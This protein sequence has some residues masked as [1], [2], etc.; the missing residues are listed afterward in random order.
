MNPLLHLQHPFHFPAILPEHVEP[1]IDELIARSN[2]AL[3]ALRQPSAP[4]TFANTLLTLE[5]ATEALDTAITVVRHLESV[6]TTPE[7]RA[8][9]NAVQPKVSE[10]YSRIPLDE[11]IW[12][13]LKDFAATPEAQTLDRLPLRLLT[14]TMDGFRR[15]GADLDPAGKQR[16]AEIE[17]ELSQITTKFMENLLDSTN[18]FEHLITDESLLA[19]LPESAIAAARADAQSKE[20]PGWRFTL[21]Q[22]SYVAILTYLDHRPT[23]ELFYRAHITRASSPPRDNEPLIARILELRR[24]KGRLLGFADFSDLVL[25]DRMAKSGAAAQAFLEDL[26]VKTQ[27]FFERENRELADFAAFDLQPWDVGYYAEK[28]RRER[29]DFDEEE[30]RPYVAA[31]LVVN[32]L[33]DA[34]SRLYGITIEKRD[35]VPGWHPEVEYFEILDEDGTRL[36]GFYTDWFPRETKRGGAWMDCLQTGGPRPDGFH[37]HSGLMCGNLTP[38]LS[39][40][41]AL[42][43]HREV[44]TIWHE[45]GHL[46]HQL[47]SR[48][49]YRSFAGTSVPWDFVELPSQIMENWCWEREALDLFARHYETGEPI[50]Q[51][52]FEKMLR[53]RTF[54]SA[55]AQMRQLS[56]GLVDLKL[57]REFRGSN[58]V[59]FAREIMSPMSAAPLPPE[60]AMLNGF[61]HL[62]S[63]S[64]AYGSG[65]YSYKWAEVLDADAFSR[66]QQQGIFSGDVG[67]AFRDSIL[68]RGGTDDPDQL[69]RDFMGRD[70]DANALMV[71]SGLV[72]A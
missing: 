40:K 56:F 64:V 69:F 18:E 67:R 51:P 35:G 16:L 12:Q 15:A 44:E 38:P 71:R 54:R 43:T 41:P 63:S 48:V 28:L 14:K 19:G 49:E 45:F 22:P 32:G 55:N 20:K 33:F 3:D 27:P 60:H 65:Y 8:A 9:Y 11:A 34:V 2:Q 17:V 24:E 62:F 53:A 5:H 23:R 10:F 13:R 37:P 4:P 47:L 39:G 57:H 25:E 68:R 21:Q 59:A 30:L 7:L 52:L 6:V 70:P 46:L 31:P 36:G 61:S 66:F 42:L 50:P 29:F 72:E 58:P 1:A 26:R